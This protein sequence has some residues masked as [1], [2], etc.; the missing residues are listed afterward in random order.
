MK[1]KLLSFHEYSDLPPHWQFDGFEFHDTNL[2]VGVNA[3][4]KSRTIK[5]MELLAQA[6]SNRL[7]IE[8]CLSPLKWEAEFSD[9]D[10][11][12]IYNLE[13]N[14]GSIISESLSKSGIVLLNRPAGDVAKIRTTSGEMSDFKIAD[15]LVAVV[16]KQDELQY[17]DLLPL[18]QWGNSVHFFEF[19]S[20]LGRDRLVIS[21][22]GQISIEQIDHDPLA[23]VPKFNLGQKMFSDKYPEV[24]R[25]DMKR[26]DY[27][28]DDMQIAAPTVVMLG[29]VGIMGLCVK[30]HDLDH[31]T[32]QLGMSQGMFRAFSLLIQLNYLCASSKLGCL[33]VD[34]IGEGLDYNRSCA[35]IDLLYE[36]SQQ[37][38][39][40]LVMTTNDRFIMNSVPLEDWTLIKREKGRAK[41]YNYENSKEKFDDFKFTG[42]SNFDFFKTD[43]VG[44]DGL[45]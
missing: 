17:P 26:L 31:M 23:A 1:L 28:I 20:T 5:A 25:E 43:F 15:N 2:I 22:A 7:L 32:E 42:F 3:S 29:P 4:G 38:N 11:K 44:G 12:Y 14:Q 27:P 9:G 16:S 34:D 6:V 41:I 8:R 18:F 21:G 30:E 37:C 24:V 45:D 35:L 13:I 10:E 19:G 40:Q 33:L 39:F 36:K